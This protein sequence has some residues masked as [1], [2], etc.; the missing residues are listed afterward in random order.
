LHVAVHLAAAGWHAYL[1][2]S[3]GPD[4]DGEFARRVLDERFVDTSLVQTHATLPTGTVAVDMSGTQHGFDI[5]GPAAWDEIE[6][7][8]DL[9]EHDVFCYG[10]L[11]GRSTV[12]RSTLFAVLARAAD[13]KALDVNLRPPEPFGPALAVGFSQATLV[14]M[15]DVELRMIAE[16][17]GLDPT[18]GALFEAFPNIEWLSVSKGA[19]GAEL[20]SRAGNVWRAAAPRV[21]VVDTVGA[22]DAFFAGLVD[23]LY[24]GL[25]GADTLGAAQERAAVTIGKRGGLPPP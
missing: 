13:F 17:F 4:D 16:Q 20:H 21:S 25:D 2:T 6:S 5:H 10:T 18:A 22:G 24:R 3:V 8:E 12:T 9:P 7:V 23:A 11:A 1:L 15:G 19:D 14:K